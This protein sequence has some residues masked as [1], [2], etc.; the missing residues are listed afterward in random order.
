MAMLNPS[1][2]GEL[3]RDQCMKPLGLSVTATAKALGVSRQ[4]LS[5]IVNQHASISPEMAIRIAQAFGSDPAFWLRLQTAY[6]L[7]RARKAMRKVRIKPLYR[8]GDMAA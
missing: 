8:D 4:V 7:A 6:D 5:D 1:H 2:P 3:L